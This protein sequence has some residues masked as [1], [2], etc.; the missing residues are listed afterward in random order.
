LR[1]K[2]EQKRLKDYFSKNEIRLKAI[3][4]NY[5]ITDNNKETNNYAKLRLSSPFQSHDKK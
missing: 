3:S 1:N 2:I 5:K 4:I